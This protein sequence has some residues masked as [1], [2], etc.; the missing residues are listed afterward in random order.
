[1][2]KKNSTKLYNILLPL[3][4]IIFIP[5][6]LWLLLIPAN[7]LIDRIVLQWSLG[8]M[9]DKGLFCRK[10]NWKICLAGFL[11]DFIG[12]AL[13]LIIA[14]PLVSVTDGS[15]FEDAA[16]G[17][18]MNPFTN[19]LSFVI[20]I[21]AIALSGACIYL[22]D[23]KILQKAGLTIEQAKRSAIRLALITAPYL[24]LIPSEILYRDGF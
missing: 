23:W 3:W 21:A 13:L 22:F 24:Y 20:T 19:V 6:W 2:G 18:M 10:H 7:Y 1:M 8:G 12:A 4:F 15:Y 17:I 5:S 11:S 14:L 9:K 16:G